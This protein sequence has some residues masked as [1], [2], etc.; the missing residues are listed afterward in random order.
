MYHG[1]DLRFSFTGV[2]KLSITLNNNLTLANA[3]G[4]S[5][6]EAVNVYTIGWAYTD[7]LGNKNSVINNSVNT[8]DI[9]NGDASGRSEEYV[10]IFNA[11]GVRY[12]IN[13][14]FN[15]EVSVASQLGT[16]TLNWEN[17]NVASSTHYLGAYAGAAF[18]LFTKPGIT[19]TLRGGVAARI[20][21]FSYEPALIPERD[22]TN[23]INKPGKA[24]VFELGIPISL[25]VQY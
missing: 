3:R 25:M 18:S 22:Y 24:G 7:F 11:L 23:A 17:E 21:S 9:D 5:P 8:T 15:A 16:F 20:S 13:E 1:I 10:G 6:T 14:R 12:A 4:I 2:E 19:G